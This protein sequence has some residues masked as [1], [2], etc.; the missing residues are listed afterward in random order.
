LVL[1]ASVRRARSDPLAARLPPPDEDRAD[2]AA[3]RA[4]GEVFAFAIC[5]VSY[6]IFATRDLESNSIGSIRATEGLDAFGAT[7]RSASS[8]LRQRDRR[9]GTAS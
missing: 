8:A 3:D 9:A 6:R 2:R 7:A 5:S 4:A 1:P